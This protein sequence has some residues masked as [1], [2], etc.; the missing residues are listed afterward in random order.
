M[1]S[2]S[3]LFNTILLFCIIHYD[4]F[5]VLLGVS[6]KLCRLLR[7]SLDWVFG[8]LDESHAREEVLFFGPIFPYPMTTFFEHDSLPRIPPTTEYDS[9]K[10]SIV[11]ERE[12]MFVRERTW[13]FAVNQFTTAQRGRLW[14]KEKEDYVSM[15][16]NS[17]SWDWSLNEGAGGDR[18]FTVV[19][20]SPGLSLR[21]KMKLLVDNRV[22][23]TFGK[24]GRFT[25]ETHLAL[26]CV[27]AKKDSFAPLH[28]SME[29]KFR[30]KRPDATHGGA[31]WRQAP[32]RSKISYSYSMW[33]TGCFVYP[34]NIDPF[35]YDDSAQNAVQKRL[36]RGKISL[37]LAL[38]QQVLI[39]VEIKFDEALFLVECFYA[40]QI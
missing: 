22:A 20:C 37:Y 16:A 39:Q 10:Y 25:F 1:Y 38:C 5:E 29:H 27:R 36:N 8:W 7:W 26:N 32:P 15:Q 33:W 21:K 17:W 9:L 4:L 13:V 31:F 3:F 18:S 23:R 40:R 19:P 30:G 6:L 14:I 2:L 34:L 28:G 11:I 35:E 12:K 24:R